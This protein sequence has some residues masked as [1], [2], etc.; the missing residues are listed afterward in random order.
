MRVAQVPFLIEIEKPARKLASPSPLQS[1]KAI[2]F[3][4]LSSVPR[5]IPWPLLR[6]GPAMIRQSP[7]CLNIQDNVYPSDALRRLDNARLQNHHGRLIP[8]ARR[9]LPAMMTRYRNVEAL[10]RYRNV[11]QDVFLCRA[12]QCSVHP[13]CAPM[14][15]AGSPALLRADVFT[16]ANHDTTT[17]LHRLLTSGADR[18]RDLGGYWPFKEVWDA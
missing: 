8:I 17:P 3:L 18:G 10:T 4:S 6:V 15:G 5:S 13:V 14:S 9:E 16:W 1:C 11:L 2:R 7:A 12:G